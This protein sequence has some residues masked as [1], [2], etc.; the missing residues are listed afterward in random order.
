MKYFRLTSLFLVLNTTIV[1][2]QNKWESFH[3]K[4]SLTGE[5]VSLLAKDSSGN[6][7][8]G[9]DNGICMYD[10]NKISKPT[11][12]KEFPYSKFIRALYVDKQ[13]NV[14]IAAQN[15]VAK[16]DGNSWQKFI[17]TGNVNDTTPGYASSIIEDNEGNIWMNSDKKLFK[18][19]NGKWTIKNYNDY[20]SNI[21][22]DEYNN[23]WLTGDNCS[24]L[25]KNNILFT[26][27]NDS[28]HSYPIGR[29]PIINDNDK[30]VWVMTSNNGVYKYDGVNMVNY[31][32]KTDQ[33]DDRVMSIILNKKGQVCIGTL[34]GVSIFKNG[35]FENYNHSNGL[36][37]DSV[38]TLKEDKLGNLWCT[39]LKG[40]S[41]FDGQT[42]TNYS[43]KDSTYY[44]QNLIFDDNNN[45]FV[46]GFMG[47][48]LL[49]FTP[50]TTAGVDIFEQNQN[51]IYPNPTSKYLNI[52]QEFESFSLLDIK[53]SAILKSNSKSS[54]IDISNLQSGVYILQ[55][56]NNETVKYQR[57]IKE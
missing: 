9:T 40:I 8:I 51:M 47:G 52:N 37:N 12:N 45:V 5:T 10:G 33:I 19:S 26:L 32:S 36:A 28:I 13:K 55:L 57:I 34:G 46:G 54:Q 50:N 18:Y 24:V 35:K 21:T 2:S 3:I 14:W 43:P 44:L 7:W 49:K 23:I 30:N 42:W 27:N 41:K 15:I 17:A 38:L 4:D 48:G 39:T 25:Y 20:I 56:Y 31:N 11:I 1:F 6:I 16:Y 53:G 22:F 29:N